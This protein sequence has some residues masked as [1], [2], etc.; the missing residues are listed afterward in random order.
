MYEAAIADPDS[1]ARV[2]DSEG[3]VEAEVYPGPDAWFLKTDTE[4]NEAGYAAFNQAVKRKYPEPD[5]PKGK[6]W[7]FDDNA[8]IR[9]RLPRLAKLFLGDSED[10]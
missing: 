4:Q 1:L 10:D 9:R 6:E 3:E 7:D 8:Q 5:S 2:V